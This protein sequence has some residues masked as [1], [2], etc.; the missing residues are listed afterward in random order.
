M[1][2]TLLEQI[3]RALSQARTGTAAARDE[4][5]LLA[6]EVVQE[7]A[8]ALMPRDFTYL[9]DRGHSPESVV[10][11]VWLKLRTQFATELPSSARQLLSL[12]S[13]QVR[14]LLLD[15]VRSLR[16]RDAREVQPTGDGSAAP[17]PLEAPESTFDP[18]QL[19]RF[20]E[21]QER[22][23][24]RLAPLPEEER[25]VFELHH[26]LDVPQ[27]RI[28]VLLGLE[29]RQVSRLWIRASN[30]VTEGWL[31]NPRAR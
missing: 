19:A 21:F 13:I 6:A 24:E 27:A 3:D 22:L 25:L 31:D 28:A 18:H 30:K 9:L 26:F 5:L 15:K 1:P 29:P 8:T 4:L 2:D 17:S 23:Q 14:H 12:L 20:T 10:S 11:E 7:R 16:R